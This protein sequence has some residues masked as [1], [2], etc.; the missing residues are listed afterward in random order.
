[1]DY[2]EFTNSSLA[3]MHFG[4]RGAL[5]ADDE[6]NKLGQAARFRIRETESWKGHIADLEAEM[7]RRG[8][9]FEMIDLSLVA[10]CTTDGLSR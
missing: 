7:I 6:L 8:M 10:D 5:A 2:H 3:M 4:A 9:R 1:M